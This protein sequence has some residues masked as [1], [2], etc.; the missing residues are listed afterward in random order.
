MAPAD[1]IITLGEI[2][3]RLSD[4][5]QELRLLR[6]EVVRSD[7]YAAHRARDEDRFRAIEAD[8]A[9][10][11]EDRNSTRRLVYAALATAGGG[12]VVQLVVAAINAKP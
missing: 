12:F 2:G 7:V 3:R 4:V 1:D 5:Q 8:I 11:Q 10:I 9:A 6:G